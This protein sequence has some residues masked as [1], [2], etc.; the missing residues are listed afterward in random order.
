L[1]AEE[2]LSL[3]AIA[4]ATNTNLGTVK[5]RLFNAKRTLRQLISPETLA[6]LGDD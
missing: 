2:N 4:E 6:L 1:Y 5:S 3:Q